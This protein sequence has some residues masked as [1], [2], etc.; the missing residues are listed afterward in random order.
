[1]TTNPPYQA[2]QYSIQ[3]DNCRTI[4]DLWGLYDYQIYN[5]NNFVNCNDL[6][7]GT[8]LRIPNL[9]SEAPIV[10]TDPPLATPT[11]PSKSVTSVTTISIPAPTRLVLFI[12][13]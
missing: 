8:P 2:T 1:M 5:A 3:G 9:S 4:G 13:I 10:Y 7:P 11:G 12:P 6:L